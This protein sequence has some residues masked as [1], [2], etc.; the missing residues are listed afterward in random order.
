MPLPDRAQGSR[1]QDRKHRALG[2]MVE[3]PGAET[4]KW[5]Q[6]CRGEMAGASRV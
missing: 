6:G 1:H 3:P 5:Q 2:S 4:P